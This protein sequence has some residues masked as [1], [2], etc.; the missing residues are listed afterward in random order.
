MTGAP[1]ASSCGVPS[2]LLA[3]TWMTTGSTS[4]AC[5]YG[6]KVCTTPCA[7][8]TTASTKDRGSSTYSVLRVKSTQKLP[9]WPASRRTKPRINAISTAMPAAADRKFC[10]ARPSTWVR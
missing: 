7:A 6:A 5:W 1:D 3:G 4:V 10:T 2:A 9:I 8:S